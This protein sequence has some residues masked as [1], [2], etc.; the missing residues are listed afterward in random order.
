[1]NKLD[2]NTNLG[3][4]PNDVKFMIDALDS[5]QLDAFLHMDLENVESY[6]S[7]K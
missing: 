4:I 7:I 2:K 1:L 5:D 6:D 3:E